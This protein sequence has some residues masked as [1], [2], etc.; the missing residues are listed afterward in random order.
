MEIIVVKIDIVVKV[1]VKKKIIS[2]LIIKILYAIVIKRKEI[3]LIIIQ[4][5][6]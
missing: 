6:H 5:W 2:Y 3:L 4:S 1:E